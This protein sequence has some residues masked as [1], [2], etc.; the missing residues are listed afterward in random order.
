MVVIMS[1]RIYIELKLLQN[2]KQNIDLKI[3]LLFMQEKE[4]KKELKELEIVNRQL[5]E[6][7]M[8]NHLI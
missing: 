6:F 4:Y 8:K 2:K 7:K 3:M 1:D 5:K